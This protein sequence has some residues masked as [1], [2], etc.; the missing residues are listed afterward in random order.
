MSQENLEIVRRCCEAFDRGDYEASLADLDAD[1]EYDLRHFPD[2]RV[3]HGHDGVR[4][5]F[6]QWLGAWEDYRQQ[7]DPVIDT[8]DHVIL[9]VRE[10]GRGKGSGVPLERPTFGVWT[11]RSGKVIRIRF[12]PTRSEALEAVGLEK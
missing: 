2:G 12:F 6:R 1:I 10:S 9:A 5:A 7:R 11:L 3:Y 4:E 8:D